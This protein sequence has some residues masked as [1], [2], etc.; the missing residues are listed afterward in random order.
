MTTLNGPAAAPG[1]ETLSRATIW[2]DAVPT[3]L[4][5]VDR[6][7]LAA[8]LE[9]MA[10][11]ARDAGVAL[12]PHAKTHK[13][14]EVARMQLEA[15]AAGLTVAKL[16]E[17][18]ALR[19]AGI[20]ASLMIA[21]PYV[22]REKVRRQLAL[23]RSGEVIA[24]TDSL[25]YARVMSEEAAAAG[26]RLDV[27][28]IVDTGY[29]R[30]GVTPAGAPACARGLAAL[31]GLRFRGIRS[32]AGNAYGVGDTG[33][34]RRVATDDAAAMAATAEAI[35]AAGVPCEIV[36]IGSTPGL[37]GLGGP[38][39]VD[40]VTEWRPGN[41]AFYDRMQ[42][43]TGSASVADCALRIVVSV[44]S[45]AAPARAII[46]AGK[47]TLTSTPNTGTDGHGLVLDHPGITIDDVSEECGWLTG[48]VGGLAVGDRLQVVP[49]HSCEMTNLAHVVAHGT[50]GTIDGFW[51][52]VARGMAW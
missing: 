47:K 40:G 5:Y 16:S 43:S 48:D 34:R 6:A 50:G 32:H 27:V 15:G 26:E 29:G 12:R 33:A 35:R 23:A 46:D 45:T 7:V 18:Q 52:P 19:E 41:Y 3:P 37:S 38:L 49:N 20:A 36:S 51:E 17:A 11:A 42:V 22:G 25:D 24:C 9:R 1:L 4:V 10:A 31:P 39:V 8:N 44:I 28:L 21:Q 13:L 30:L 14:A 2:D